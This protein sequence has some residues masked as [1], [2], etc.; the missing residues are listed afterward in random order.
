MTHDISLPYSQTPLFPHRCVVCES[1]NPDAIAE[2]KIVI[3][4][5]PQGL[6]NDALDALLDNTN[7]I[8]SNGRVTLKPAV[9]HQC[10]KGLKRYH[11][12]NRFGNI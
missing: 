4:N 3:A 8:S 1:P 9:C 11:F 12:G 2:L 6:A 10:Q 5:P 7:R